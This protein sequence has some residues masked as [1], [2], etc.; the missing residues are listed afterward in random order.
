MEKYNEQIL[1]DDYPVYAGYA[2]VADKKVVISDI[3]GT[4]L[5][6]KR[7]LRANEITNCDLVGR[8]LI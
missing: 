7:Y 2:Y 6:L 8:D 4:V 5:S 3:S 1:E